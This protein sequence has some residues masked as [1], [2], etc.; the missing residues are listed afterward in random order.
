MNSTLKALAHFP[1]STIKRVREIALMDCASGNRHNPF[2]ANSAESVYY[3]EVQSEALE[4]ASPENLSI[5]MFLSTVM[6]D[7]G[8]THGAV[9]R[10][11]KRS[12]NNL[13]LI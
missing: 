4:I 9:I 5:G 13:S 6:V 3:D 12:E 2:E 7:S 8:A 1:V 11:P 10:R